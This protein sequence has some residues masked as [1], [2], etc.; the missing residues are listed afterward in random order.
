[1]IA[2][3]DFAS[4]RMSVDDLGLRADVDAGGRLVEDQHVGLG[5][6]PFGDDDLLLRCRRRACGP[7]L[8]RE[9]VLIAQA[10]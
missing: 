9:A 10:L 8:S 1:M 4:S 2:L 3:P 7:R 5:R 6:Q